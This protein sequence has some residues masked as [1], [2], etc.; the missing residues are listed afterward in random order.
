MGV[1]H[2]GR[3][4]SRFHQDAPPLSEIGEQERDNRF[5]EGSTSVEIVV[6]RNMME[7]EDLGFGA[8]VSCDPRVFFP[9]DCAGHKRTFQ[10][11]TPE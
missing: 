5:E 10:E 6:S 1:D 11:G 2:L 7:F 9:S 3:E 4:S 8:M